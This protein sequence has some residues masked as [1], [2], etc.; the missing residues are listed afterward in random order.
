[1]LTVVA[2]CLDTCMKAS[3]PLPDCTPLLVHTVREV[4][5]SCWL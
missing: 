1:V 5:A 4:E 3:A 2:F